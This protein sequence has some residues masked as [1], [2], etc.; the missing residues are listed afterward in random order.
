MT[1]RFG[2][3]QSRKFNELRT[4]KSSELVMELFK[5]LR[6]MDCSAC[7]HKL[8]LCDPA[9]CEQINKNA[10]ATKQEALAKCGV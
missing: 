4:C 10:E 7:S 5:N 6:P 1:L 3:T 8:T 9:W 2:S